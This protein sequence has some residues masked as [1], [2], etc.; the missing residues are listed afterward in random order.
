MGREKRHIGDA[1]VRS[2][3]LAEEIVAEANRKAEAIIAKARERADGIRTQH[4]QELQQLAQRVEGLQQ[5]S[6]RKEERIKLSLYDI[7]QELERIHSNLDE[8][9]G[10]MGQVLPEDVAE[11]KE[12]GE[13]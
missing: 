4:H 9:A 11:Q 13:Q 7:T 12:E 10:Q 3:G 8:L 2:Q 5:D 1:L 6:R